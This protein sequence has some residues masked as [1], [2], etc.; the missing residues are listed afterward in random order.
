MTDHRIK[1]HMGLALSA[2]KKNHGLEE[3]VSPIISP[4]LTST[5]VIHTLINPAKVLL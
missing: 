4:Q 2:R 3:K 1:L 5:D